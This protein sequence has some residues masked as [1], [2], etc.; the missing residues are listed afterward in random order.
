MVSNATLAECAIHL[1]L[2][3]YLRF[4]HVAGQWKSNFAGYTKKL[5]KETNARQSNTTTEAN[6]M[7][8]EREK[9]K[10]K[11]DEGW[12]AKKKKKAANKK[13][14]KNKYN[15]FLT[16]V[17]GDLFEAIL[18]A[19]F[20][21]AESALSMSSSSTDRDDRT[22]SFT[23]GLDA[24]RRVVD[25]CLL[26]RSLVDPGQLVMDPKSLYQHII[27]HLSGGTL[28]PN[29]K[30]LSFIQSVCVKQRLTLSYTGADI[31]TTR[32]HGSWCLCGQSENCKGQG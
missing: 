26:K 14:Q 23:A 27:Q 6:D 1:G 9:E 25:S 29:Y 11:E 16:K 8:E 15:S 2:H 20:L 10:G 21:D 3:H 31:T 5:N 7:K 12:R 32:S 18:G 13:A 19:I 17:H 28:M 24:C 22:T 30:V 4:M